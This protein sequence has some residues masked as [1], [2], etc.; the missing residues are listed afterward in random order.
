MARFNVLEVQ[1]SSGVNTWC[2]VVLG[3]GRTRIVRRLWESRGLQVSRLIR[4]RFGPLR[5]PDTLRPGGQLEL[6]ATQVGQLYRAVG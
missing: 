1:P 3:E 6:T 5:L 2:S 4:T